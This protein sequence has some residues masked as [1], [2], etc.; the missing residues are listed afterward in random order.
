MSPR[1]TQARNQAFASRNINPA[2]KPPPV[3]V[4]KRDPG[5]SPISRPGGPGMM[6][7]VVRLPRDGDDTQEGL[8][9]GI[10]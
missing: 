2:Y 5:M 7:A 6:P 3:H 1:I 9:L 4:E 8:C 10:E